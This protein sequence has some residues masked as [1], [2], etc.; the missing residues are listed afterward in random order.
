MVILYPASVSA[1]EDANAL[2]NTVQRQQKVECIS[3][4]HRPFVAA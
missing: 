2:D 1:L 4:M 3:P